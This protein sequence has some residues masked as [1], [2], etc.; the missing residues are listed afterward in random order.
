MRSLFAFVLWLLAVDALAQASG[1][2]DDFRWD[3]ATERAL[4]STAHGTHVVSGSVASAAP[5]VL[6]GELF[7]VALYP[8]ESVQ[9]AAP[10]SKV[11]LADGLFSGLLRLRI[12]AAGRYRIALD[13]GAWI[14][15]VNGADSINPCEFSG[16]ETCTKPSKIVLFDLPSSESLW[17]QISG[18]TSAR[19]N[20]TIVPHIDAN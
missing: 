11:M 19:V 13:S 2:C 1:G 16:A 3:V 4:F 15:V 12:P 6:V 9:L 17:L 8:Q 5:D 10:P 18:A 20:V 7:E 14:Y